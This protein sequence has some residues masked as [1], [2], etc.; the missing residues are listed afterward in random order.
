MPELFIRQEMLQLA[1]ETDIVVSNNLLTSVIGLLQ[2]DDPIADEAF[3]TNPNVIAFDDCT[4]DLATYTA[5]PHSSAD[6]ITSKLPFAYDPTAT[7]AE[8]DTFLAT[9]VGDSSDFLQEYA[10]Y[11]LTS[12]TRYET[13]VWL[14]GPP[15]GGKSTFIEGIRA[16][17]GP[18]C[19]ILGLDEIGQSRFALSQLPG[20]TVAI[21]MEQPSHFIKCYTKL[22]A[23]ISGEPVT[24]E[25]KF[26][27]QVT[28]VPHAKLMWAM[29]TLPRVDIGGVGLF[30]RVLPIHFAAIPEHQRDPRV[31]EVILTQGAAIANWALAG[32]ARLDKR[33]RFDIPAALIA[34]RETYRVQNDVP[35]LFIDECCIVQPERRI[36]SGSLY[37][38][39]RN[40]ARRNEHGI[41]SS[42][43]WA[44][45]MKRLGFTSK[46]FMDANYWMGLELCEQPAVDWRAYGDLTTH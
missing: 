8:W 20:K 15:G 36:K 22:N 40:W 6:Y 11:C 3:D 45:E 23:I 41:Q 16:M 42:T 29:N 32:L 2:A 18:K 27:D 1:K 17:L 38:S 13:A 34:D 39:Y 33:Q 5:R 44:S 31:K 28:V 37:E 46:K 24:V 7:S 30:R 43:S 12:S 9:T 21:S 10:G 14:W 25:R 19:C 35:Q 4:Y 26:R